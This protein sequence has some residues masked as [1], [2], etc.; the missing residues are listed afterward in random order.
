MFPCRTM[1]SLVGS[2]VLPPV[3]LC[4]PLLPVLSCVTLCYPLLPCVT[5]CYPVFPCVTLCFAVLPFVTLSRLPCVTLCFLPCFPLSFASFSSFLH[6]CLWVPT[7]SQGQLWRLTDI[8][9]PRLWRKI[10][11]LFL[12]VVPQGADPWDLLAN[13]IAHRQFPYVVQGVLSSC[14]C[15]TRFWAWIT[16]SSY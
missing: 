5:L 12:Q 4:Y 9:Y 16:Q 14:P 15:R 11:L 10:S 13:G 8:S 2:P 3:T 6:K 1:C 7:E